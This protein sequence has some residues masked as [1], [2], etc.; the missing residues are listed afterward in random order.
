MQDLWRLSAADL[1]VLIRSKK[2][3]AAEAAKAALARLDAVNPRLNAVIDHRPEDVLK[4]AQA[5]DAIIARGGDPGPL[6]GVPV[7]VKVNIDQEGF[8]TTNG[9][10]LQ[11][12][13]IAKSNSPVV[14][15]LTQGRRGDPRSH[16]LPRVLLSLVHNQSG[17]RRHQES[18]ATHR[19]R[20]EVRR[21][22]RGRRLRP[23]SVTS[24]MAPIS[25]A[26][27]ATPLMP[28]VCTGCGRPS[29]ACRPSTRRCRSAA[30]ARRF[31]LSPDRSRAPLP[32]CGLR[33]RRCPAGTRATPG[34][35]RRRSRGRR[36]QNA[37]R[38]ASTPTGSIR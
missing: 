35:C 12:D 6:A 24:R 4:Q 31:R 32:T 21:A 25:L 30:S 22:V 28:A 9:L 29:G 18:R 27:S 34:G 23:A 2:V 15:N 13:T 1:A 38:S 5:L 3:S 16:Q 19:S 11:A 8:A 26:R 36:F 14:D 20:P 37:R 10:K 33:W 7:T 17:P